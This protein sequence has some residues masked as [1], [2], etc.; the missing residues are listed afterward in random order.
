MPDNPAPQ[1]TDAPAAAAKPTGY[2]RTAPDDEVIDE[3]ARLGVQPTGRL[4]A[5]AH[6]RHR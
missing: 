2:Y 6:T 1:P 3:L 5:R 4:R